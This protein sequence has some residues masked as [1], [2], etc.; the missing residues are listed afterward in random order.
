VVKS[1]S[2]TPAIIITIELVIILPLFLV[3]IQYAGTL[4]RWKKVCLRVFTIFFSK[5]QNFREIV[6]RGIRYS[7]QISVKKWSFAKFTIGVRSDSPSLN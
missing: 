4:G 3:H 6:G 2:K 1:F 7:E 5:F